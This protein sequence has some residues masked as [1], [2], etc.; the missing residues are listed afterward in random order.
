MELLNFLNNKSY[1]DGDWI[2]SKKYLNVTNP[3]NS[4]IIGRVPDLGKADIEKAIASTV[5]NFNIWSVTTIQKRVNFL[6]KWYSLVLDN[7]EQLA[8]I[9]SLEQGK[10]LDDAR[11]EVSYAASFIEWF[12]TSITKVRTDIKQGYNTHHQIITEYEAVGP[13]AAITPWNFPLAMVTRKVAPAIAAGCSVLVKP[14][15]CTPFSA[16]A[17]AKLAQSAD[18]PPGVINV[19]TGDAS[20]IGDMIC[21]EFRIRKISFTGSTMVGKSLYYNSASTLKRMSL[22]LGGNAPFIIFDS[23]NI[24]QVVDDL[25]I[26]KNRSNGQSCTSPN[27]I[28]I[29]SKIYDRFI[30]ILAEKFSKVNVGDSLN[31]GSDIGPLINKAAVDKILNLLTEAQ[32]KGAKILCGGYGKDNFFYPTVIIDCNDQ[33]EIA[34]TEIFGP[35]LACYKFEDVDEAILRAND[36]EYGL[37]AYVYSKDNALINYVSS[38]LDFGMV[39]INSSLA[40]NCK[41]EFAGRKNSGFGIEGGD[42]GI[43]EYL[44]TKYINLVH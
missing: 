30:Q 40:S 41:A 33:M 16:L 25:I 23:D 15:S 2:D 5:K 35:V 14:S 28:F 27:R 12:A 24:N 18:I 34:K 21:R 42:H 26:S 22:E 9:I 3:N 17:I 32:Q 37:Q 43:Y 6:Q 31:L 1:V 19:I 44:N 11:R 4:Q 10:T 39:S 8:Y 7:T 13:V 29:A 38:K 20:I 36:T